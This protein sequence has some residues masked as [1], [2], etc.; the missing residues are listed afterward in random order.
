[1]K[2]KDIIIIGAGGHAAVVADIVYKCGLS[3]KGFLDDF[4]VAGTEILGAK[5]LGRVESCAEYG[6]CSF[7]IGIGDNHIRQRIAGVYQLEYATVVHPSAVI[8]SQVLIGSGTVVMAGCVIN[9]RTVIGGHCIINTRAGIDHDNTL[10]DFVHVSP[11]GVTGG[12]VSIGSLT[13]IGLGAC[14]KNNINICENVVVGAGAAVVKDIVNPG[15]YVGV[16]AKRMT[17]G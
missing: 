15:V 9:P 1:M 8:S 11:G 2:P 4:V 16:P 13:H 10:G 17:R 6:D 3:L 7:I 5:V 12:T 14:V